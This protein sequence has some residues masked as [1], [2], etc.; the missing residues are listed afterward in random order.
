MSFTDRS[1]GAFVCAEHGN[2]AP[3]DGVGR[4][5]RFLEMRL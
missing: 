5:A 3:G 1:A 4:D 2:A